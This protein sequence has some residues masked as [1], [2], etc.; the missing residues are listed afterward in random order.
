MG[1]LHPAADNRRRLCTAPAGTA[2][3]HRVSAADRIDAQFAERTIEEAVIGAAAE[4]AVSDEFE[5]EPLLQADRLDYRLV[6][7]GGECDLI[8]LAFGKAGTFAHQFRRAQQA[9]DM[10]GAERRLR[11]NCIRSGLR[12][13]IHEANSLSRLQVS[14]ERKR[15]QLRP[16]NNRAKLDRATLYL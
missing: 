3:T 11:C 2:C 9:A 12:T 4:F 10:F 16:V 8:D 15:S 13:E 1:P 7:S 14:A 5:A 6:F